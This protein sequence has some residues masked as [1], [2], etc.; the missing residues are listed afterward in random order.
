MESHY[1]PRLFYS[2]KCNWTQQD[3]QKWNQP[4][5]LG[6]TPLKIIKNDGALRGE[7]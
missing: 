3:A 2:S 4:R 6:N 5:L 7:S 1:V